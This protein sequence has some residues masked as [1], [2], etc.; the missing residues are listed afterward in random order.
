MKYISLK[1]VVVVNI[2]IKYTNLITKI[3]RNLL[4]Y[5]QELVILCQFCASVTLTLTFKELFWT[6]CHDSFT[7][8]YCNIFKAN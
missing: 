5:W 1:G 6:C 2:K 7:M 8:V 4:K 3:W